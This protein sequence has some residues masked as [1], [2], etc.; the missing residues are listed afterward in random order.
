MSKTPSI[1]A[2][3]CVLS[4]F[5]ASH[6]LGEQWPAAIETLQSKGVR[7]IDTFDA[8][9]GLKGYAARFN[10]QGMTLYLTEDGQHVLVGNLL[11]A[12]GKNLS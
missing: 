3:C 4:L 7:I 11:D 6:A 2:L 1:S 10:G 12:R 5:P 8:P 9:A